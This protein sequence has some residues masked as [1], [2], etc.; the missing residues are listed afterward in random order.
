MFESFIWAFGIWG[1]VMFIAND[2]PSDDVSKVVN[3]VAGFAV[4]WLLSHIV[5]LVIQIIIGVLE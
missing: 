3:C 1:F 4:I 5:Q 2:K